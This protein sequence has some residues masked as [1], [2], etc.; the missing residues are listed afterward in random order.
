MLLYRPNRRLIT[1]LMQ[2]K[3]SKEKDVYKRQVYW[4]VVTA[5]YLVWGFITGDWKTSWIVWPVAGVL[6]AALMVACNARQNQ[7]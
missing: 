4:L 2:D 1:G 3:D 5:G 6:F 7:N